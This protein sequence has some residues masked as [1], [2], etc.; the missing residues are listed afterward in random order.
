MAAMGLHRHLHA[1]PP[2]NRRMPTFARFDCCSQ[3]PVIRAG[4][5]IPDAGGANDGQEHT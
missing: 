4:R 3:L 1:F 2:T 5:E